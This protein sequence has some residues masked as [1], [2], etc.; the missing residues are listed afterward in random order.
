M[1][2]ENPSIRMW[3]DPNLVDYRASVDPKISTT[4]LLLP[5]VHNHKCRSYLGV[6]PRTLNRLLG[7]RL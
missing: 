5:C 3:A 1:A 4:K 2:I 6:L 7:F